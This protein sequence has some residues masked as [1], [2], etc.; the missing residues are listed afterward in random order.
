MRGNQSSTGSGASAV[1]SRSIDPHEDCIVD[2]RGSGFAD[3]F[4]CEDVGVHEA[5]FSERVVVRTIRPNHPPEPPFLKP[6]FKETTMLIGY[7]RVSK[8]D[9]SQSLDLQ[10]RGG[11]RGR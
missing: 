5:L 11:R 7:A 9:G 2:D 6:A 3:C 4:V 10:R 8:A 1:D